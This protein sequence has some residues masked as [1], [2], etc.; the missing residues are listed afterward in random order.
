M[1]ENATQETAGAEGPVDSAEQAVTEQI[2][3]AESGAGES[4]EGTTEVAEDS[5]SE[6]TPAAEE[7]VPD[8]TEV[9]P[10]LFER[11]IKAGMS[12]EDVLTFA[13]SGLERAIAWAESRGPVNDPKANDVKPAQEQSQPKADEVVEPEWKLPDG[14]EEVDDRI[15][16]A[17]KGVPDYVKAMLASQI[18]AQMSQLNPEVSG[19]KT[20]IQQME[21]RRLTESVDRF[22]SAQGTEWEK[23]YGKGGADDLD[24]KSDGFNKRNL[25]VQEAD[26]QRRAYIDRGEPVP[27]EQKL[28]AKAQAILFAEQAASAER[29]KVFLKA[30][31]AKGAILA[32]PSNRSSIPSE[33][34]SERAVL[35]KIES[36]IGR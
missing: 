10:A 8:L 17:L 18:K 29:K 22:C 11:A 5:G 16:A 15:V 20:Y 1:A 24:P 12:Y 13:P 21:N 6:G 4:T 19:L 36:A 30:K 14:M 23:V 33:D 9:D 3:S 27:S 35:E 31:S 2:E 32:K 28:F 25:L 7:K 34:D 26:R